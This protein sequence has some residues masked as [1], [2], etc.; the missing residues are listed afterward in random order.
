MRLETEP[1]TCICDAGKAYATLCVGLCSAEIE[2]SPCYHIDDGGVGG[3]P[4]SGDIAF[5][6]IKNYSSSHRLTSFSKLAYPVPV[7][8][9]LLLVPRLFN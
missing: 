2:F 8:V 3:G 6:K 4:R 9:L 7:T 5:K 1:L